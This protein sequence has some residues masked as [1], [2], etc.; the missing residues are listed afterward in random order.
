MGKISAFR[1][2]FFLSMFH[3]NVCVETGT[4]AGDGLKFAARHK[5]FERLYSCEIE[6]VLYEKVK[7]LESSRIHIMNCKSDEFLQTLAAMLEPDDICLFWLDAHFPGADFGLKSYEAE[8][9]IDTRLPLKSELKV[10]KS[11]RD[12]SRDVL[13]IDDLRIYEK[14]PFGAGNVPERYLPAIPRNLDWEEVQNMFSG[15]HAAVRDYRHE[16]YFILVPKG[17]RIGTFL[18]KQFPFLLKA[19]G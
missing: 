6:P 2:N 19:N 3:C 1:L 11:Q 13:I 8:A 4:G 9:N 16:G 5:G 12:L 10:L 17:N 15:S 18:V 14:G 7:H